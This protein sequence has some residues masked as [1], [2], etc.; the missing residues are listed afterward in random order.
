MEEELCQKIRKSFSCVAPTYGQHISSCPDTLDGA[1]VERF[2]SEHV[3]NTP[4][5]IDIVGISSA[6][7][8]YYMTESAILHYLP[9]YL[10]YLLKQRDYWKFGV[11]IG[12]IGF[13]NEDEGRECGVTYPVFS[14]Q[15][16]ECI[17][18]FLAYIRDNIE[19]YD[20]DP[21]TY[22]YKEEID[23]DICIW[24]KKQALLDIAS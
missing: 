4:E 21:Y 11:F 12:I 6:E 17:L 20:M 18:L 13:L 23:D 1:Y 8:L 3:I 9:L 19:R 16:V 15:Q 7:E 22:E 24:R 5:D 2:F 14:K 10:Q